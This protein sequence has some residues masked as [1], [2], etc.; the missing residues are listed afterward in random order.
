MT[1]LLGMVSRRLAVVALV[2][3]VVLVG[4]S[5][6]RVAIASYQLGEQKADLQRQIAMLKSQNLQLQAQVT[7]LQTDAEIEQLARQELGWTK[8]GDT[9][10]IVRGLPSPTSTP[11]SGGG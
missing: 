11:P 7:A 1:A 3:V 8:P 2:A 10:V 5:F 9:E 6:A 4:I